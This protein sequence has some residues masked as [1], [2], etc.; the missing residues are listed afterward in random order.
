MVECERH[1]K[2]APGQLLGRGRKENAQTSSRRPKLYLV[3]AAAAAVFA[4]LGLVNLEA[5]SV[6]LFSVEC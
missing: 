3:T 4:G 2:N 6:D 5:A 1:Q